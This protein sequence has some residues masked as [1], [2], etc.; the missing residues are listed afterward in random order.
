MNGIVESSRAPYLRAMTARSLTLLALAC[1]AGCA[2]D[3]IEILESRD[4]V[5]RS[6]RGDTII[7]HTERDGVWGPAHDA[8]EV[9][10]ISDG[11]RETT[12]GAVH[13]LAATPDGGVVLLDTKGAE[14]IV[15]RQFDV[16]GKFV[17]NLGRQGRG[18]GEYGQSGMVMLAASAN[19]AILIR[20][21][22]R[23]L[24]R[25]A[26]D[27]KYLGEFILSAGRGG[28]PDMTP[29]SDGTIYLRSSFP[30][31][32]PPGTSQLPAMLHFDSAGR[33][34]DSIAARPPWGKT[35]AI[36]T[37]YSAQ[38]AWFVL[39][40]K[41]VYYARSDRLGFLV[42]DP[43]RSAPPLIGEV[44]PAPVPYL[45]EERAELQAQAD[46]Q[47]SNA[48]PELA[49]TR[50]TVPDNKLPMRGAITDL[51]GRIWLFRRTTSQKVEPRIGAITNDKK[52]MVTY[53]EP[54]ALVAFQTNGTYLGEVRFPMGVFIPTFVGN[55]AWAMVPDSDGTHM[56]VKFRIHD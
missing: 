9:R 32:L 27:G 43:V 4:G 54:P 26:P 2:G 8:I 5:T 28:M 34:L 23:A 30:R 29:A 31:G 51:D 13:V 1:V 49:R 38:Q 41:R 22:A 11:T 39:P 44:T 21:G 15:V 52:F 3:S 46:F 37:M 17:R 7:V 50:V 12:F 10:R 24:I 42:V 45:A 25:Y 47:A 19:G 6:R 18:P 16:D 48:P 40:D 36:E 56:L 35:E 20:D 53:A 33:L 14:G 55:T